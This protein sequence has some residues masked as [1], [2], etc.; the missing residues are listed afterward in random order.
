MEI[1]QAI[2]QLQGGAVIAIPTETVYGLAADATNKQAIE[3]IFQ[4]KQRPADNPLIVH[5]GNRDNIET[6]AYIQDPIAEII[7]QKLMP[8]PITILL[9]K[10]DNIPNVVTAGSDLVAIRIPQHPI[11]LEILQK[12]WL[13]LA[14]PSANISGKPSPTNVAMVQQN[15]GAAIDIIDGGDCNIWI[16]STVVQ[17]QWD[18]ILIH[19]PWFI[20]PEDISTVVWSEI[21]VLYSATQANISPGVKYKHYAPKAQIHLLEWGSGLPVNSPKIGLIV[22]DERLVNNRCNID[23]CAY[24]IY[25]WG[26]HDNLLECTQRLYNL[27]HQADRDNIS[28]IYVEALPEENGIAYAIMNRVK[29]SLLD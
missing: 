22:T 7:I 28:D 12:S 14:A 15:F 8:G 1:A 19:R 26:S 5:V 9:P 17:V 21:S 6:Y 27:Y 3:K 11:A 13:A 20:T 24:R 25:C 2:K 16:E 18:T 4:L 23:Q 29:K 10:R